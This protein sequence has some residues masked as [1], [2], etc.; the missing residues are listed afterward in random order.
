MIRTPTERAGFTLIE[1]LLAL[2]LLGILLGLGIVSLSPLVAQSHL[3]TATSYLQSA[4]EEAQI[5]ALRNL[6][7]YR[8]Q[9]EQQEVWLESKQSSRWQAEQLWEVLPEGLSVTAIHWPSFSASSFA[10]GG[11]LTLQLED[12]TSQVRVSPVGRIYQP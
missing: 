12:W 10:V 5:R 11:T 4:L 8:V 9:L 7:S 2:A 3:D 6:R 1:L